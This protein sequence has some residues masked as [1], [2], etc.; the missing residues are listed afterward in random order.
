MPAIPYIPSSITVHL[1]P[2]DSDA[3]NVTLPFA[4]YIANVAS[5]EIY[6]TWP[7]NAIRANVYA[8]ISYALNRIYTEYYRSRGYDFDITNSTAFDQS[9]VY[10]RDIFE[11][12]ERIVSEIFT[13][14]LRRQGNI[15]PL[16][17]QY[18][19]GVEVQCNGLSQW[20]TVTLADQGL[21]PY[22]ILQRYYGNNIDIVNDAPVMDLTA[23]LPDRP[24]SLGSAGNDVRQIQV[25]LNRIAGNYP[26]IPK[27]AATDGIFSLDTEEAV[28]TFQEIFSLT[29]DGIVGP[30]TWYKIQRIYAS[31]KRL[32]E[33]NS[34]GITQSDITEVYYSFPNYGD[35]GAGVKNLQYYIDYLSR[36][37]GTIPAV[38]I[39]GI[40]GEAT[41]NAVIALQQTLGLTPDGIVGYD[42]WYAMLDAY[43]GILEQLAGTFMEGDVIPFPGVILRIG[44]ESDAVALMQRYLNRIAEVY[45]DIPYTNPTGY[46]GSMTESAVIAFQEIFG[47]LPNG[48]VDAAT[49]DEIM[50][51]YAELEGTTLGEG[52]Y[53]GFSVGQ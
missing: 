38:D 40:F 9:F 15:E 4:D 29:P 23:S 41:R 1:G 21:T 10:G 34:E 11:N 42:T 2:P 49:W 39:D 14:Y 47:L 16:F 20:G 31:V 28:R 45:T 18:C 6:P 5:S 12:V 8:Q 7:E 17:A 27:I 48:I 46:F 26:S 37:Y 13:D 30:A 44:V 35:T 43:D 33:L 36:F 24:L 32:S 25:R 52:Q 53:P 50:T 19:D 22:Q 51:V 3:P